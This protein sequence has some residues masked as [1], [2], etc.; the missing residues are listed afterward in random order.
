MQ[1]DKY[2]SEKLSAERLKQCY[3]IVNERI[4][5]YLSAEINFVL[6]HI[7]KQILFLSWGVGMAEY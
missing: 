6:N 4:K 7:K 2:Y 1:E 5:Q 3:D